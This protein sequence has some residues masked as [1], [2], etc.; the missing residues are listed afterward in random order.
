MMFVPLIMYYQNLT[1]DTILT[2]PYYVNAETYADLF[3]FYK[4]IAIYFI[5]ILCILFYVL[6]TK[7]RDMEIK[8]DRLKYYIP[9]AIYSFFIILSTIFSIFPRIAILGVYERYEGALVLIS[10]FIFM[11]YAMEVL[12]D[13]INLNII[14]SIFLG[15]VSVVSVIGILQYFIVDIFTL[16]FFQRLVGIPEGAILQANFQNWAYSTLYNPNNLGQFASLTTPVSIGIFLAFKSKKGKIFAAVT[17]VLSFVVGYASSSA[18]FVAGIAIAGLM[19]FIL[20][21]SYLIPK[22]KKLRIVLLVFICLVVIGL[23]ALSGKIWNRVKNLDIVRDE[24][25]SIFPEKDDVYFEDIK[26]SPDTIAF[27]TTQGTF[28]LRYT[29]RGISFYDTEQ[30]YVE[31]DQTNDQIRFKEEPFKTQW[32][33]RIKSENSLEVIAKRSFAYARVEIIFDETQFLGIRGTGGRILHE[34]MENQMPEKFRGMETIASRRGYLWIVTMSK[35]DEV[36][37]IGS[38]PDTYLYWFEQNDVIGKINFLHSTSILADKPHNW[39][40]QIASQ[41]GVISLLAFLTMMGIYIISTLRLIGLRRKKTYYE[42]IASG[43]MC[44]VVGFMT[45]SLFV[46]ST[47]GVK[48]IKPEV[49]VEIIFPLLLQ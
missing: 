42:F 34:V 37:F 23:G 12:K 21:A 27:T 18:N 4:T 16:P 14:F 43:I 32:A 7:K 17:A 20:Y 1:Y 9:V 5:A 15:M 25:E 29:G 2:H 45:S 6:Y 49:L 13:E 38:G 36:F 41:T 33:V 28:Y 40:L 35:L 8:K 48:H 44:G 26:V 10:Y 39:Y 24:I 46:D 22:N 19:F 31:F 30:N 47:V 11:V 3:S